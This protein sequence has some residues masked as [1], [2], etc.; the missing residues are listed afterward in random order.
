MSG[1]LTGLL[2]EKLLGKFIGLCLVGR[3][4]GLPAPELEILAPVSPVPGKYPF[5]G[6]LFA[7][8][9]RARRI[10][11][12]V[13]TYVHGLMTVRTFFPEADMLLHVQRP[14]AIKTYVHG[15]FPYRGWYYP[16]PFYS[17][18]EYIVWKCGQ[19]IKS[20]YIGIAHET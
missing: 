5:G 2:L 8:V 19:K 10:E 6:R 13:Q 11:R 1:F 4:G 12:T 18:T 9:V 14:S 15:I 17:K 16:L 20:L 3:C 7:V